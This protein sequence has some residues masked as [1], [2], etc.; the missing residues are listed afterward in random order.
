MSRTDRMRRVLDPGPAMA[1][2]QDRPEHEGSTGY[3]PEGHWPDSTWVLSAIHERR[4]RGWPWR[5]VT[6]ADYLAR[7][8]N[9][10]GN[11]SVPPCFRWFH[12]AVPSRTIRWPH[13]GSL[14]LTSFAA[15]LE[16]LAGVTPADTECFAFWGGLSSGQWDVPDLWV[17]PLA[18]LPTLVRANGGDHDFT[19][20]NVWPADR[21]WFV[22]TDWDLD[23]TWVAGS[24]ELVDSVRRHPVL[25]TVEWSGAA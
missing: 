6:W 11:R 22:W 7:P 10:S 21:S 12:H 2:L 20:S 13:E 25:E 19:P 18:A 1:W 8:G 3:A 5:R 24:A 14:D 15:L 16:V 23:G 17:G 9:D 4:G